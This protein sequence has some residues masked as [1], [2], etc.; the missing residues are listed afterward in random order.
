MTEVLTS[1]QMR[2]VEAAAIASG[3]VTGLELME[4]AGRGV[5]EAVFDEWPELRGGAGTDEYW[6]QD[7][8]HGPRRAVVL[9]GPGN[10]GGDGFVVA[11]L[12][13]GLGWEVEVYL[14][15]DPAKLPPD[16]RVNYVR[17]CGIGEVRALELDAVSAGRPV[18]LCVD[19]LFG[20]GLARAVATSVVAAV[21]AL[22][23]A[24]LGDSKVVSVD[25]PSGLCADSGRVLAGETAGPGLGEVLRPDLTVSFHRAKVG[26]CLSE[27]LRQRG[28]LRV[29]DIGLDALP[30][31]TETATVPTPTNAVGKATDA[32]KYSH[33]HALILSGPAGRGG[34]A[35]LAARGALRIGAGVVTVGCAADALAEHASRLDA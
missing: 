14:Y 33:G 32:H 35:R 17:W 29:V 22:F 27:G 12:L 31:T 20:T 25:L 9:C 26:H 8:N 13:H 34:A 15:G 6:G 18:A 21:K 30:S 1:A 24:F 7:E 28:R 2:A 11:R 3:T 19:A 4:R 10:N 16:A 5:V 23:N